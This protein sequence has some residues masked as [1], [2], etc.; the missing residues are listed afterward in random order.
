ML[1]VRLKPYQF[2]AETLRIIQIA[3]SKYPVVETQRKPRLV[4]NVK[5]LSRRRSRGVSTGIKILKNGM[6]RRSYK[7]WRLPI[8]PLP[9]RSRNPEA[10]SPRQRGKPSNPLKFQFVSCLFPN[11]ERSPAIPGSNL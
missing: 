8:R 1:F 10:E 3:E 11:K 7:P 5:P 2:E 6:N 9:I 4:Q